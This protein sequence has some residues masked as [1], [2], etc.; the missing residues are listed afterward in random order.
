M[1]KVYESENFSQINAILRG[2]KFSK[3]KNVQNVKIFRG[4]NTDKNQESVDFHFVLTTINNFKIFIVITRV[5]MAMKDVRSF[6]LFHK[7]GS[8][9]LYGISSSCQNLVRIV[10]KLIFWTNNFHLFV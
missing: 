8:D 2:K 5:F 6:S 9:E 4:K 10:W 7:L 3:K 1:R